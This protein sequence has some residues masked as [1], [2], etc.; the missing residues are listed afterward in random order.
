MFLAFLA[1]SVLAFDAIGQAKD[2][3][4]LPDV[5]VSSP[6]PETPRDVAA[7]SGKWAGYFSGVR[8]GAYMADGFLVVERISSPSD[9]QVFF[10]GV[11]RFGAT[12]GQPYSYRTSARIVDG[13][14]VFEAGRM[15]VSATI[16]GDDTMNITR[17]VAGGTDR[18]TF[19]R[20]AN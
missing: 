11:S 7:F 17:S 14:L 15:T 20:V 4:I 1:T 8:S 13:A 6:V 3:P 16:T 9:V 5:A 10:A 2:I 19:K 12:N 18:S